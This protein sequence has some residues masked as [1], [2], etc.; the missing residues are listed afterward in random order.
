MAIKIVGKNK[1]VNIE[2]SIDNKK[3]KTI[4]NPENETATSLYFTEYCEPNK[5]KNFI[6]AVEKK[7]R[8][9]EQYSIYIGNLRNEKGLHYCAIRGNIT[10]E[11]ASIEFHHY[12]FS[13]YDIV[14][15]EIIRMTDKNENITS[16]KVASNVL[17]LHANNLISLVPLCITEHQLV[18]DGVKFV[19]LY[20]CIGKLNEYVEI[21]KQYF[22]ED[23]LEKYNKLV[24]YTKQ[25]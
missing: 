10:D 17:K 3:T 20:S 21:Y 9:S 7:I 13:L 5:L 25:C 15:L 18:H 6:K 16:F 4:V 8:S 2:T 24:E 11:D 1:V 14:Y 19:P 12:P 23:I 22:T